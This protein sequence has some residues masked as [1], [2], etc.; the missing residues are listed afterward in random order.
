[1]TERD[2]E[3]TINEFIDDQSAKVDALGEV[4]EVRPAQYGDD[5]DEE[6]EHGPVDGTEPTG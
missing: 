5:P 3:P 1:M 6:Y 2:R 4:N